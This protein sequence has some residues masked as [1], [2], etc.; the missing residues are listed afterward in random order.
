[1][2]FAWSNVLVLPMVN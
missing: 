2:S 1:M